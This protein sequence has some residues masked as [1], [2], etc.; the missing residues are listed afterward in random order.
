MAEKEK[1]D[2]KHPKGDAGGGQH[3]GGGQQKGGGP[4]K[5]AKKPKGPAQESQEDAGPQE[6]QQPA[7][8]AR[9]IAVYR[10]QIVPAMVQRFGYK[11]QMS[12]PKLEKVVISMGLGK[13]AT[14][15]GEGKS[16]FEKAEKELTVIAG[17]RPV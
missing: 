5:K 4:E 13:F 14:A 7:P 2:K 9:L 8:P 11:N 17:Q 10:D 16:Q 1:Q 3:K 15:G 12:V 6:P